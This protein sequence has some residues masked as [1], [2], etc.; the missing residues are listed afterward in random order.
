MDKKFTYKNLVEAW[1]NPRGRAAI[2]L[3]GYFIFMAFVVGGLKSDLKTVPT[4]ES[5][6]TTDESV[7]KEEVNEDYE[8]YKNYEYEVKITSNDITN[9]YL[10]K[11]NNNKSLITDSNNQTYYLE[12]G[13]LYVV[14]ELG[15]T[16][17]NYNTNDLDLTMFTPYNINSLIEEAT[18]NYTTN[19]ANGNIEKNYILSLS[20]FAKLMFG[21]D[22]SSSEVVSITTTTNNN[23]VTNVILDL[24]NYEKYKGSNINT[25]IISIT[26]SN[27]NG[28]PEI[29]VVRQSLK[30]N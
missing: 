14:T 29:N 1:H 11:K 23:L 13:I 4:K 18:L 21:S 8:N 17:Y 22:I 20:A 30:N 12:D 15:K 3:C 28:V 7:I 6:N 25:F 9:T 10:G 5:N 2:L 27:L 16:L 26:Y 24:S 19:F